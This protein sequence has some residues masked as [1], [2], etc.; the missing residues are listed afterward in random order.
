VTEGNDTAVA[1]SFYNL[2]TSEP[3][4]NMIGNLRTDLGLHR[5]GARSLPIT[6]NS[7][8]S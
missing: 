8:A 4:E 7:D 6:T 2:F 1:L 3:T 5:V